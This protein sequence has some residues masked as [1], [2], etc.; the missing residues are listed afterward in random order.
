MTRFRRGGQRY[1]RRPS[2]D[3]PISLR[4]RHNNNNN[5]AADRDKN[6]IIRAATRSGAHD[7][8]VP[9]KWQFHFR[10]VAH[11][12]YPFPFSVIVE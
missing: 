12:Y 6:N 5:I 1:S 8:L 10:P 9:G 7:S 2:R 4:N 3:E 11:A